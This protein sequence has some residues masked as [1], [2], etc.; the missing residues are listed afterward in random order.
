M[1]VRYYSIFVCLLV[2]FISIASASAVEYDQADVN[3]ATIDEGV[4]DVSVE[5]ADDDAVLGIPL[6]ESENLNDSSFADDIKIILNVG[7][8]PRGCLAEFTQAVEIPYIGPVCIAFALRADLHLL[9]S[10]KQC[11]I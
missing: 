2:F 4:N 1:K 7:M 10:E 9:G 3:N 8:N 6:D 11:G 5:E